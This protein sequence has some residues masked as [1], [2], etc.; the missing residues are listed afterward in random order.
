MKTRSTIGTI[1]RMLAAIFG[2]GFI[3]LAFTGF[4]NNDINNVGMFGGFMSLAAG[5]LSA[6]QFLYMAKSIE[7]KEETLFEIKSLKESN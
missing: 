3:L 2:V 4:L 7:L 5:C 6:T 1:Y